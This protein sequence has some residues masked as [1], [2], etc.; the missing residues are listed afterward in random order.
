MPPPTPPNT[1]E[2]GTTAIAADAKVPGSTHPPTRNEP[3]KPLVGRQGAIAED[4]IGE[5][6]HSADG[7]LD[8]MTVDD[9]LSAPYIDHS[10][11][12]RHRKT[13]PNAQRDAFTLY[14]TEQLAAATSRRTET[15][16]Q[17]R[18]VS[19]PKQSSLRMA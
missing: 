9:R 14:A 6:E 8:E 4:I 1:K 10:R 3:G 16:R 2:T 19:E 18:L 7:T 12:T 11:K 5:S 17:S 13:R 15:V